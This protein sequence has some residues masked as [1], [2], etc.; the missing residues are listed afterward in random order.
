[1]AGLDQVG[2][3]RPYVPRLLEEWLVAEPDRTHRRVTGTLAFVDLSGFT[4]LT[5]RLARRGKVGA[6]EMS[7]ALDATFTHLMEVADHDGADLV[8]WG[9]DAVLL[10]FEGHQHAARACRA[11]HGMRARLREVGRLRTA[12]G[13]F[14]LR[15]SVGIHSGTFD[16]FLV[17]D[18]AL[19]REL[20]VTGPAASEAARLEGL[21]QA[22]QIAIGARTA[23]LLG[24]RH[25]GEKVGPRAWLLKSVPEIHGD[26]QRERAGTPPD[27]RGVIP[28]AIRE[29]LLSGEGIPE[30]RAVAVAFV[31]FAGTDEMLRKAGPDATGA[32]L[33]DVVR[34]VANAAHSHGVTFFESDINVDGGKIM[35]VAGAPRSGGHDA[36]RLL[37]TARR[38]V[39]HAGALPLRVG[40]NLG[41]VFSS[42]F[43]PA[44]RRTYSIKGD[45]V[46]TAARVM[47]KAQPGEVLATTAVVD[48][49]ETTFDGTAVGP[50]QM[51]G[52]SQ[53]VPAVR[54]GRILAEREQTA[55]DGPLVGR[56]RELA[57]LTDA[58]ERAS[59]GR[60]NVVELLGDPGIGKTRLV[61]EL[62]RTSP[63][64]AALQVVCDEYEQATAY[65]AFRD[66]LRGRFGLSERTPVITAVAAVRRVVTEVAA[67]L[68][69]WLPLVGDLLGIPIPETPQTRDLDEQF[70][71]VR[72]EAVVVDLMRRLLTGPTV[73]VVDDAQFMDAA[74]ADLLNQLAI[75]C[76]TESWLLIVGRRDQPV[77]WTP[78]PALATLA[79]RLKPLTGDA[80]V[81]L[82]VDTAG[83]G[84]LPRPVLE[85]LAARAAGNPLFLRSLAAHI[86]PSGTV[87]DLPDTIEDLVSS[88]IDQ[89]TPGERT[90]LRHAAVLGSQFATSELTELL[91]DQPV[92]LDDAMRESLAEFLLWEDSGRQMRFRH[93]LIRE[94]AYDGLAYRTRQSLHSEV[95][96]AMERAGRAEAEPELLSLHCLHAGIFDKAFRYARAGGDAAMAM[97]ANTD[98]AELYRRAAEAGRRLPPVRRPS[99]EIGLVHESLG[100]CLFKI[101][102][103]EQAAD[104]YG[105]ARA[106]LRGEPL[107]AARIVGKEVVI[108]QRLRH[109]PTSLRRLSRALSTLAGDQRP[110]VHQAR[111]RLEGHY[112]WSRVWQGRISEAMAWGDRCLA[113]ARSSNDPRSLAR[114]LAAVYAL[115]L[116]SGRT[117]EESVGQQALELYV[118]V[119]DLD[120]QAGITNNL[121]YVAFA[122]SRWSD[123]ADQFRVA[124]EINRRLGDTL[125]EARAR[126][127]LAELLVNQGLAAEAV[128]PLEEALAA[129]QAAAD[130]DLEAFLLTQLGRARIRSG[131]PAQG[132]ALLARARDLLVQIE[133]PQELRHVDL[134]RVEGRLLD[135]D[136]EGALRLA[137]ELMAGPEADGY[138]IDADLNWLRGYALVGLRQPDQ[139]EAEFRSG[140]A[141]A[142]QAGDLY[143]AA[144]CATGLVA[145]GVPDA[146][147]RKADASR[148]LDELGVVGLPVDQISA[149]ARWTG[150]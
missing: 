109:F 116:M 43:G 30:H 40:V 33:D 141:S 25:V 129:A 39:D 32:A 60:G 127:N 62:I 144:L 126:G 2:A 82:A 70:R 95:A 29:H 20:L 125:E 120:G 123:A 26:H 108:D 132:L 149:S 59:Y 35:L 18:P 99:R 64:V 81:A 72:L 147:E 46:N 53:L 84:A 100:D 15:M 3:L 113:S 96:A 128:A 143:P 11:A 91:H 112:A 80:A 38:I 136:P 24:P 139:A 8:K 92:A 47:G 83:S 61:Q 135:G 142:G 44:F 88:Q 4:A 65:A 67:D 49:A 10:M 137:D 86:G 36:D 71:K 93:G 148:M 134:A 13:S 22:G 50:F 14:T 104:A 17:G 75:A 138:R 150:R 37:R 6:E 114:A 130:I 19:H 124:A 145:L 58:L 55:D 66:L 16:Y 106:D 85:A 77:G 54:L 23:R 42:D 105:R 107:D 41:R 122:E 28:V 131:D 21:A 78:D 5:E 56:D 90:V 110:E 63:H 52:K 34:N 45:A 102:L 57:A 76:A 74:A 87:E 94:A 73:L 118:Q 121:A 98:A 140:L 133:A 146:V 9:G 51:K 27:V 79:L 1:M 101:G 68:E 97:Y 7:D 48:A 111:A 103:T 12:G 89:L 69:P 117:P 115:H 119:G 31:Q